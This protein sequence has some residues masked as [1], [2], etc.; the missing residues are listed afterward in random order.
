MQGRGLHT[1]LARQ[2]GW[3]DVLT[4]AADQGQVAADIIEWQR[5]RSGNGA[6]ADYQGFLARHADWPGLALLR[7]R[8]EAAISLDLPAERVIAYFDGFAPQTG[9]GALRLAAALTGS[10]R[11]DVL[12]T[13]WTT[14]E[15]SASEEAAFLEAYNDVLK[16]HHAARLDNAL[17]Q[18]DI[19][20]AQR[21][22]PLVD[23]GWKA[24]VAARLALQ[25]RDNGVD[26]LIAVVPETLAGDP[27]LAF[28]RMNWRV[29]KRQRSEAA[30]LIIARSSSAKRLGRPEA[31]ANW[32]RILARQEMREGKAKR[33]YRLASQHRLTEGSDYADL[34]WLSGY[35]S[36]RY[37]DRPALALAHFRKFK[38]A[39]FTPISLG[40]AGYWQGRALE[41][42]GETGAAK[43][44][45]IE[46][47]QYQT[48][49]YGLLAAEK[50]GLTMDPVLTGLQEAADWREAAFVTSSV[51]Q[52]AQAFHDAGQPWET[53]RFLRHLAERL[54][55]DQLVQLTDYALSLGDPYLAVRVAKQAASVGIVAPRAY[56]PVTDLGPETL[57]VSEALALSIARRESEFRATVVSG[58]GARGLMQLMPATAKAMSGKLG[59]PYSRGKLT[60]DPAYNAQLGSAY[61]AQRI[62]EFGENYVLVSAG[63]N[64][65]PHRAR[66]WVEANG[67]PRLAGV[68]VVDWI[69]HIPFRETRNYV[70]RVMESLP[71]YRARL[72]GKVEP[73]RLSVELKAE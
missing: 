52:A 2:G 56:F 44:A 64:A 55:Q 46:G 69:E 30:D 49:F 9:T 31:W 51:F 33:A 19:A 35:L 13:A 54:P 36:L 58:A 40:R 53:G 8:G 15:I 45:Y 57:L 3:N 61:L 68:D 47:G 34:E 25:R 16:P 62:E 37:L 10:A 67:D 59:L 32:R 38:A 24:L 21:M 48:S 12:V 66:S 50:A 73:I 11:Q 26:R 65:G 20:V 23:N 29:A 72:S 42:M 43:A 28:D 22:L 63:Y 7:K 5:L 41:A 60:S 39:V 18:E 71:V 14:L 6:F 70:M 4:I 27:G 17:W 1:A